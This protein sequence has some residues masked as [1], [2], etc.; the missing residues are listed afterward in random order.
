[1]KNL[2]RFLALT[3]L[4]CLFTPAPLAAQLVGPTSIT[5]TQCA[6]IGAEGGATVGIYVSGTFTG[7]LQPQ[8]TIQGQTA[9]NIQVTPAASVTPQSTITATGA[10]V[11]SVPAYSSF[12]LCGASVSSGTAVVFLNLSQ[13]GSSGSSSGG[14]IPA[15]ASGLAFPLAGATPPSPVGAGVGPCSSGSGLPIEG[16][17]QKSDSTYYP[18]LALDTT[19]YSDRP[20]TPFGMWEYCDPFHINNLDST[21]PFTGRSY[22]FSVAHLFGY[23]NVNNAAAI[24]MHESPTDSADHSGSSQNNNDLYLEKIDDG[25]PTL[26]SGTS[27]ATLRINR[28]SRWKAGAPSNTVSLDGYDA[29]VE[30]TDNTDNYVFLNQEIYH[31]ATINHIAGAAWPIYG[32]N[33][34]VNCGT[35]AG[36]CGMYGGTMSNPATGGSAVNAYLI[37]PDTSGAFEG[38]HQKGAGDSNTVGIMLHNNYQDFKAI[39]VPANPASGFDRFFANSSTGAL[40]C[41]TS[42]GANCLPAGTVSSIATTSPITGGTITTTG[43]IACATCGVTGSPLSQFAATTSAQLAG[44]ISD[45]TGSGSAV[46]ATSPTLV[47]PALGTP[48]A[49]VLTNATGLPLASGVTGT[50]PAASAPL[51]NAASA[52]GGFMGNGVP[53]PFGVAAASALSTANQVRFAKFI[54]PGCTWQLN[55]TWYNITATGGEHCSWAIFDNPMTSV[56]AS[57]GVFTLGAGTTQITNTFTLTLLNP[58]TQYALLWSCDSAVP[59]GSAM[60]GLAAGNGTNYNG[61]ATRVGT[62]SNA[63]VAGALPSSCGTPSAANQNV[64]SFW[65]ERN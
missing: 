31:G 49:A 63:S 45:E 17:I 16:W 51:C 57:S 44:V 36:D 10:Y 56:L 12:Q 15:T 42:A 60:N 37:E 52:N 25:T 26:V 39:A 47:T 46:F 58:G 18:V 3:A 14:V 22:W 33:P 54:A 38:I 13:Q 40:N 64:P 34:I 19:A 55:N 28:T 5:S 20:T 27:T 35:S 24:F 48:S 1:M 9:F 21:Q 32:A 53:W 50:L 7:T 59:T 61:T 8:G 2:L 4:G 65:F 29:L 41:L 62:C 23:R 30:Q 11:A 43:T 6:R